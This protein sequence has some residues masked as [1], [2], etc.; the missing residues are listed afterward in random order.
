[1]F[2]VICFVV[3]PHITNAIQEW[4]E[5]VAKVPVD[6]LEGQPDVCIVEVL[7]IC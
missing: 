2:I 7:V 1:M 6:G 4:V 3:V 5:R